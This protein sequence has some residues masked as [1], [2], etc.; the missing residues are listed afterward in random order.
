MTGAFTVDDP[1]QWARKAGSDVL[2]RNN[3][4]K[5]SPRMYEISQVFANSAKYRGIIFNSNIL[6]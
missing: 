1:T 2:C 3:P 4:I 6:F 5:V